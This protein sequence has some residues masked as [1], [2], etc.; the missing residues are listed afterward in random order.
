[1]SPTVG[2][3]TQSKPVSV[4][5]IGAGSSGSSMAARL[6]GAGVDDVM[7]LEQSPQDSCSP[8]RSNLPG[9]PSDLPSLLPR[10]QC[11][12][13]QRRVHFGQDVTGLAFAEDRGHWIARTAAG[14]RF[15][16]R[17]VVLATGSWLAPRVPDI[18]GLDR[19]AGEV[20]HTARWEPG[21]DLA[22]KRIAVIGTGATAV[23][24]TP[25]LA[26]QARRLKVFQRTPRWILP[27]P[28]TMLGNRLLASVPLSRS[29]AERALLWAH[30][31]WAL[32]PERRHVVT[33]LIEQLA[34]AHLRHRVSDDWMRRLLTPDYRPGDRPLLVSN[35][36]YPTLQRPNCK[37]V[38]WPIATISE[39]GI[40]TADAVEHQFDCIILATGRDPAV[41]M[42]PFPVVGRQGTGL[43]EEWAGGVHGYKGICIAGFPN[44]FFIPEPHPGVSDSSALLY[45]GARIDYALR[46][47]TTI[48]RENIRVLD[49]TREAQQR[50]G[51]ALRVHPPVDVRSSTGRYRMPHR[52]GFGSMLYPATAVEYAKLAAE[53]Q[54]SDYALNCSVSAAAGTESP[55]GNGTRRRR[56]AA[57]SP[58]STRM[59]SPTGPSDPDA[60]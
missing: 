60:T 43:A 51:T 26:K 59:N 22:D 57:P 31:P 54:L 49:V 33:S 27:R 28:D 50:D 48:E 13:M 14:E 41:P 9:R 16:G 30:E 40:R 5:I 7:V 24:V 12:Q 8:H 25:E 32:P 6:V 3:G 34:R 47:I 18:R 1:M 42:L 58:M 29:A 39:T 53:L 36:Y 37:L 20:L 21:R 2:R 19:F 11:H 46:A 45:Q 55:G 4:L 44:L 56:S 35:E 15:A 52:P 17:S 10:P 23:Q 38:T